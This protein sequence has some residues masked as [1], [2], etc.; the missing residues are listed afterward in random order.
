MSDAFAFEVDIIDQRTAWDNLVTRIKKMT[1]VAGNVVE[2]GL[3]N[4]VGLISIA[5]ENEFGDP[6]HR[7]RPYPIPE[8]SFLRLVF[9]RD[10]DENTEAL[11]KGASEI[12]GETKSKFK[13]LEEIGTKV[14]ND[15]KEFILSGFYKGKNPNHPITI[16]RKGHDFPLI[17]TGKIYSTLTYKVGKGSP[18]ESSKTT[19]VNR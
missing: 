8:R 18:K 7:A 16:R 19:V 1:N 12:I 15:I 2:I 13:V 9:D 11:F 4:D 6:P 17:Q 3:F 14:T 5:K 10:L